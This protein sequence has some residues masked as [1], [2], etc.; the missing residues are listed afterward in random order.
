[1]QTTFGHTLA[2]R[3][4]GVRPHHVAMIGGL[5]LAIATAATLG[6]LEDLEQT[7]SS[8]APAASGVEVVSETGPARLLVY[9][10]GTEAEKQALEQSVLRSPEWFQETSATHTKLRIVTLGADREES[11]DALSRLLPE[12]SMGAGLGP[13]LKVVDMR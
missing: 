8:T 7:T 11:L 6:R 9:I 10:V 2:H 4:R 5:A 13:A 1:M 12:A 3:I